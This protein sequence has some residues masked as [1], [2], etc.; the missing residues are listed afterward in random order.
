MPADSSLDDGQQLAITAVADRADELT[1]SEYTKVVAEAGEKLVSIIV[2]TQNDRRFLVGCL[3]RVAAIFAGSGYDY[4]LLVV[5]DDSRDKTEDF[6]RDASA[7]LPV[8]FVPCDGARGRAASIKRGLEQSVG[9]IVVLLDPH[10]SCPRD[11]FWKMVSELDSA[12][13]VVANRARYPFRAYTFF[14]GLYRFIFGHILLWVDAD[15][16]SGLKMFRR[17]LLGSLRFDP[18]FDPALGFDALL[19]YH[20]RHVGWMISSM[21]IAYTRPMFHHGVLGAFPP[22]VSLAVGVVRLNVRRV[23]RFLLPFLYAPQPQD[24]FEAGFTNVHD[25]LFLSPSQSAQGH[26]TKETVSLAICVICGFVGSLFVVSRLSNV[27]IFPLVAFGVSILYVFLMLFKLKMMQQSIAHAAREYSP[28]E[29]ASMSDEELP[30]ISIM[31]P[32]YKETEVIPQIFKY[33]NDFDY[34]VEKLDII[35]ILESTDTETM[36]GFLAMNPPAHFKALL[37]P[38]VQPKTKP[39]ALNVAFKMAKGDVLVIYDAEVLPERDQLK[40]ACLAFKQNPSVMYLHAKMDV[41]NAGYNLITKLYTA[42]FSYFYQFF[43]PG[44]VASKFPLPISGHSTFFRREVITRVGAWDGYNLA[45]DCDIGIRIFRK[46][47]GSGM[48]LESHTWEQSTTTVSTW[49]RQRTRWV[50][51]F[52]QTSIVQLRYPLLLKKELK[53]WRNFFAFLIL[54]PGNV[55]LV[56]LNMLQW[57]MFLFWNLTSAP[58]LQV[59]YNGAVLYVA[60]TSFV[61]GNFLFVFFAIYSLYARKHYAIAPWGLLTFAY[62]FLHGFATIRAA[63]RFFFYPSKWD[64]TSHSVAKPPQV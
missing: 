49:V 27:P 55:V 18:Q 38:D 23:I 51:G 34:P 29:L 42:E 10:L 6:V 36:Q 63:I 19:L 4:E 52:I 20:A 35:F 56:I 9:S 24:Y 30:V 57:A 37:S 28:A 39:K 47:F 53:S 3:Q 33:L 61:L 45:E 12:Q 32:L 8:R 15:V 60:M 50:Q 25:Y 43:F 54:V 46:G 31:I 22:R 21:K 5:D 7:S 48:M 58:F 59:A 17:S 13:I 16:R 64:K 40:K 11:E 1:I 62:W 41:Y 2:P 14:S 44:L 26:I